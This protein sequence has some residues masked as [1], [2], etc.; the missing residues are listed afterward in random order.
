MATPN[1][2]W[3][4]AEAKAKREKLEKAF[5]LQLRAEKIFYDREFEFDPLRKWRADFYVET[6]CNHI[7]VELEGGV[8]TTGRHVRGAG[9]EA[10]IEKY[11]EALLAGYTLLRGTAK[12]IK[13]GK[14]LE[15]VKRAMRE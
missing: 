3:R 8:Y 14:L 15:W 5:E 9:Y 13:S 2:Q 11:N 12:H 4:K 1:E 6:D 10:D 7:L